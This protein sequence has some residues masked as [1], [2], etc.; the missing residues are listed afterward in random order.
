MKKIAILLNNI[1][2]EGGAFQYNQAMLDAFFSLPDEKFEKTVFYTNTFWGE[3][4]H[5]FNCNAKK[6]KFSF[7]MNKVMK[8]ITLFNFSLNKRKIILQILAPDASRHLNDKGIDMLLFPSQ[9][10]I[11]LYTTAKKV[12]IIH[13]LMHKYEPHFPEVSDNGRIK[14][15]DI[16]F[17][18]FCDESIAIIVDSKVGSDHVHEIYHTSKEKIYDLPFIPPPHILDDGP[19]PTDFKEKYGHLPDKFLFYPSQFWAHKNHKNLLLA[20]NK[21]RNQGIEINMV[22]GGKLMY[23]YDDIVK[24][25]N[26]YDLQNHI[27]FIGYVPNEYIKGVYLKSMGLVMPTFFGPTNIPPLEAIFLGRP[28]AVSGIYAMPEQLQDAALYFKP[29]DVDDIAEKLKILWLD[30]NQRMQLIEN[31]KKLIKL[32]NKTEFNKRFNEI[33]NSIA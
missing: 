14:Y 30:E 33:I 7:Y 28:V 25:I 18:N 8:L 15:R 26:Q 23:M 16:L 20:I 27:T 2:A 19:L 31:G 21:L 3:Y 22:F 12:N 29:N 11:S 17:K 24:F 32:W 6:L 1:P 5:Q 4:L 10:T 9:D 13:D